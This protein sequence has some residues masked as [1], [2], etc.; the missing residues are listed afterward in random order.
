MAKATSGELRKEERAETK[1]PPHF[2]NLFSLPV[3]LEDLSTIL[4]YQESQK[5]TFWD[6][7]EQQRAGDPATEDSSAQGGGITG[8]HCFLNLESC[9]TGQGGC[10]PGPG[11][12]GVTS[13]PHFDAKFFFLPAN[14]CQ[15]V[16]GWRPPSK[17][18]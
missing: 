11:K 18:L 10:L 17:S 12:E 1:T 3:E 13:V 14:S 15:A 16:T 2:S 7:G 8:L 4:F 6:S 5:H 9:D